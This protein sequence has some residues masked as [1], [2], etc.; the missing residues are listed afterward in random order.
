MG[1]LYILLQIK[2]AF[3]MACTTLTNPKNILSLGPNRSIL[4]TIIRPDPVLLERKGGSNGRMSFSSVVPGAGEPLQL[5]STHQSEVLCNWQLDDEPPFPRGKE[6]AADSSAR[7][8]GR[9]RKS[10]SKKKSQQN[11]EVRK[12]KQ[13][14]SGSAKGTSRGKKKKRSKRFHDAK[15]LDNPLLTISRSLSNS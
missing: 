15:T 6:T 12:G 4:G 11:G 2:S 7:S 8:S 9:K 1:I 14:E 10:S 5:H 3:A 13:V